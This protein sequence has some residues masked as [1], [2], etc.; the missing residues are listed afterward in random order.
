MVKGEL[1]KTGFVL[2]DSHERINDAYRK[3]YSTPMRQGKKN[4]KYDPDFKV[5]LDTLGFFSVSND[6]ALRPLLLEEPRLGGFS[7]F[8]LLM[9]KKRG[10][11]RTY[12]GHVIPETM[13]DII[14]VSDPKI[15]KAFSASFEPLDALV[16]KAIGGEIEYIAYDRLPVE[17]MMEYTFEFER[18]DDLMDF[19]DAFQEKFEE[20]FEAHDYIIAGYKDYRETYEGSGMPFDRY[21]A[22]WVYSLCHFVFS[23]N[24]FNKGHP[25][26]GVFAPCSMYMYIEKGK[27][28]LHIGMPTLANWRTV[29]G[30]EDKGMLDRIQKIDAE[31]V[32]IMTKEVGA[33][34]R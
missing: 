32:E 33:K 24:I 16:S 6:K 2:S 1:E 27:N 34:K 9:F 5:T 11:E 26:A 7:P 25:E 20:A 17:R 12:V 23:Y 15:R 8:N 14:G 22:Y 28:V 21:D 30:I 13:L 29:I 19:I 18:P 10:D 31:I 3:K 4:P